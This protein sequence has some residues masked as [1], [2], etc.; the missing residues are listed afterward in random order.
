MNKM[1]GRETVVINGDKLYS[2]SSGLYYTVVGTDG[3]LNTN[4]DTDRNIPSEPQI[5]DRI[6]KLP[7]DS[8][9]VV[10]N[11]DKLYSTSS[12]LYYKEVIAGNKV[13]YELVGK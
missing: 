8:K 5:G 13:Y 6:D 11:G 1:V 9:T 4:N 10:I 2:T 7:A 12:G 3:A